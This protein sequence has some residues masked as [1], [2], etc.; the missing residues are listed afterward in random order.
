M[1]NQNR[2]PNNSGRVEQLLN[3]LVPDN[4]GVWSDDG[5]V[6]VRV[7]RDR[8]NEVLELLRNSN[9][10]RVGDGVQ[11]GSVWVNGEDL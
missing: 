7:S 3:S 1:R 5:N 9:L 6:G 2:V 4:N 11:E 8:E 10:P